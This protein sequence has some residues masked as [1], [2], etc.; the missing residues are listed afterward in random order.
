MKTIT[1]PEIKQMREKKEDFALVNVVDPGDFSQKHIG[2]S[3]NIPLSDPTFEQ[4]VE[5]K[6][7]G[8]TRTVVVYCASTECDASTKAATKL[9]AAG[10]TNVVEFAGGVKE[11]ET[12]GYR[13]RGEAVPATEPTTNKGA[14]AVEPAAAP[15]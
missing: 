14:A 7:G 12:A 11:W 15:A 5:Q 3:A 10:F 2:G 13:L 9:E 6:L 8:K 4:R 1:A